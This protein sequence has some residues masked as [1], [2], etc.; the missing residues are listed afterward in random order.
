MKVR[1]SRR[2]LLELEDIHSYI[3]RFNPRAAGD[4]VAR[5]GWGI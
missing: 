5:R 2:A 4:V 3:T 1:Y